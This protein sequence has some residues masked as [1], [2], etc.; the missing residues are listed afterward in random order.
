M[1]SSTAS[2]RLAQ[3]H[4][5]ILFPVESRRHARVCCLYLLVFNSH[6]LFYFTLL[7]FHI[8]VLDAEVPLIFIHV[9]HMIV[10]LTNRDSGAILDVNHSVNVG[11]IQI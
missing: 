4:F 11:L 2:S 5:L 9:L 8:N 10:L 6:L 3:G 1:R 7:H